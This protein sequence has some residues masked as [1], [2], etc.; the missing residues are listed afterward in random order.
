[1]EGNIK[2]ELQTNGM[3][4]IRQGDS[5][6]TIHRLKMEGFIQDLGLAKCRA[7]QLKPEKIIAVLKNEC[8]ACYELAVQVHSCYLSNPREKVDRN[9]HNAFQFVDLWLANKIQ[10]AVK[11]KD[12]YLNAFRIIEKCI[13]DRS[14]KS[15]CNEISFVNTYVFFF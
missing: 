6:V 13:F 9:F 5:T 3:I 10:V 11:G 8:M 15:C 2:G 7:T 4:A 14:I 12:F 1:M